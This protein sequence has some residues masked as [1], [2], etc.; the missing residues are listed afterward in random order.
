MLASSLPDRL[1]N[2]YLILDNNKRL[3]I[4]SN[5]MQILGKTATPLTSKHLTPF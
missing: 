4:I 3:L 2:Y 5:T 1:E